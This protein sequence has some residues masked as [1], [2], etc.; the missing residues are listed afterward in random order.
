MWIEIGKTVPMMTGELG[1][2]WKPWK[3][4]PYHEL[5]MTVEAYLAEKKSSHNPL[6]QA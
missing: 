3:P 6:G 1:K 2:P 5:I 4:N